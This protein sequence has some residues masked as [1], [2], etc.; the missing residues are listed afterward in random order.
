MLRLKVEDLP[1]L[2]DTWCGAAVLIYPDGKEARIAW[3]WLPIWNYEADCR[4]QRYGWA[5]RVLV[6]HGWTGFKLA[7]RF[8]HIP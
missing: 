6:Y 4:V 5:H 1:L 7:W 8:P 3:I 2:P